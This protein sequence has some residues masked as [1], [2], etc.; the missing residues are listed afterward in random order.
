MSEPLKACHCCGLVQSV[1]VLP[2][3][4]RALCRRCHAV[5][6]DPRRRGGPAAFGAALA[7]LIVYPL[8]IGLPVLRIERFGHSRSA[9]IW[10]GSVGLLQDGE[11]VV[12]GVVLVCSVVLPLGKLL[13]LLALTG[14]SWLR[15][16]HAALTYRLVEWTGR[17][18]MLDVLLV[19][20]L[21]AWLK[22]G[23][24]VRVEAQPA[25]I[26]FALVVVLSLLASAWFDP[27]ALWAEEAV[28]P[29]DPKSSSTAV[30]EAEA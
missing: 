15:R 4:H 3:R 16:R 7:A 21:V 1:P 13:A 9:S 19:A 17:W 22:I 20:V 8:A 6:H 2:R 28:E 10:E 25:A 29:G 26:L 5:V 12:G 27:H 18:G 30:T 23:E 24:L 14:T 11:Y